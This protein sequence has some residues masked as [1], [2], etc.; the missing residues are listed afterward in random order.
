MLLFT[1]V[2]IMTLKLVFYFMS[3]TVITCILYVYFMWNYDTTADEY[4]SSKECLCNCCVVVVV[5]VVVVCVNTCIM[6]PFVFLT[7][8]LSYMYL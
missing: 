7:T 1:S 5:V 6:L 3:G 8:Y 4:D 2:D